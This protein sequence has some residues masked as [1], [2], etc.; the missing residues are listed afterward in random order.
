M[1][2]D[3]VYRKVGRGGAGNFYSASTVHDHDCATA[4]STSLVNPLPSAHARVGR[5]GAGNFVD[6]TT[7]TTNPT[8]QQQQ[9]QQHERKVADQITAAVKP[10]PPRVPALSGRGGAGNWKTDA[11]ALEAKRSAEERGKG[12]ELERK[13]RE[14][15]EQGLR[16]PDKV[17][18]ALEKTNEE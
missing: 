8:A 17:H 1:T 5:G 11:A 15:V 13:V 2:Q 6:T 12:E 3:D 10:Q 4:T 14:V 9:Q 7:T 18:H 16:L